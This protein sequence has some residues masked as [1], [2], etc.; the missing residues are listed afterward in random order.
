MLCWELPGSCQYTRYFG[1][2]VCYTCPKSSSIYLRAA[3]ILL[4]RASVLVNQASTHISEEV[5]YGSWLALKVLDTMQVKMLSELAGG[6]RKSVQHVLVHLLP[7]L[8]GKATLAALR[9]DSPDDPECRV[10]Y[11]DVATADGLTGLRESLSAAQLQACTRP[12]YSCVSAC[13][14]Q[15]CYY[16]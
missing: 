10:C 11:K 2:Q 4:E 1:V 16:R 3:Y 13:L 6:D 15:G 12:L 5:Y 14:Q 8:G 7:Y 9:V